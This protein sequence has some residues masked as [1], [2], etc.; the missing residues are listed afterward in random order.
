MSPAQLTSMA[1]VKFTFFFQVHFFR[2]I[3]PGALLPLF[4]SLFFFQVHFFHYLFH[5]SFSRYTFFTI[6]F[7]GTLF[8]HFFFTIFFTIFSGY[9][10]FHAFFHYFFS[11]HTIFFTLFFTIFFKIH[12]FFSDFKIVKKVYPYEENALFFTSFDCFPRKGTLFL[13][14]FT[15]I[16][17]SK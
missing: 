15:Q 8:S 11:G 13:L 17:I 12:Y 10:F 9:T 1:Q 3:F 16:L 14:F 6:L 5:Y 2:Y 7:P 4:V